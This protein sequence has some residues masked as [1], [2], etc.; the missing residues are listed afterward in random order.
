MLKYENKV[1]DIK[2]CYIGGGSRGW[3]WGFMSDLALEPSMSGEIRLFDIDKQSALNNKIIGDMITQKDEA[4]GKW[5]YVCIDTIEEALTGA[6]FIVMSILPGTFDE[7][8]SDVH[9]PESVG[10]LQSVGDTA[11]PGGMIRA[12]R[13]IPL[14][15]E[16]AKKIKEYAPNA[17]VINYTN[18]MSLCVKAL[19]ETFPEIK[20]IG[21]C[22]EVFGTQKLLAQVVKEHFNIEDVK[23]EEI[24]V[25]VMGINHFTWLK[26]AKY[27]DKDLLPIY[28]EFVNKY[29][30]EG[31]QDKDQNWLN[32]HFDSASRVKFD[33]FNKYGYIAAAGDR[34]LA[35][36][37]PNSMYLNDEK[38]IENW[39]FHLTKVDWR[40]KDLQER[41]EKS[42][43]LV[44]GEEEV[45]IKTTGEEGVLIMKALVGLEPLITNVNIT[46]RGQV[47]N[48][49]INS[50][51]ETNGYFTEDNVET[52]NVG[53]IPEEILKLTTPH[54]QNMDYIY[55][56]ATTYDIDLVV[57]AFLNDPMFS[58][59][60]SDE[61]K[62]KE[63]ITT[64]LKNTSKYLPK[65]WN[66]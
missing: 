21:C 65:E 23:R 19:Y 32:S 58:S 50:I 43:K 2:I 11:G 55:T 47:A 60:C 10:V 35:E 61:E 4:I 53:D 17:W 41:L 42:R 7:M 62:T 25:T 8:Y 31:Y 59:K 34:H 57:K 51:V 14:Y 22:H 20:A 27:K 18:P 1:S 30:E 3:A 66:L 5:D 13:T 16:Y 49:P 9:Q 52:I 26:D 36:F 29:F 54:I 44:S 48:L 28:T 45:Q 12:L 37:M 24:D 56:A 46:N 64:M 40:K 39:K 38:T 33:L 63:L 6:D 15:I